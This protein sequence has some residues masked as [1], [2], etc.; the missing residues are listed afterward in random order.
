MN[1]QHPFRDAL[2]SSHPSAVLCS[3]L[4]VIFSSCRGVPAENNTDSSLAV[5]FVVV[6]G[7]N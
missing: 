6:C 3:G 2:V 4:E 7:P 5:L 1:C